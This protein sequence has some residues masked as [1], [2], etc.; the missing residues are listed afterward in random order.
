[1]MSRSISK[2]L[3]AL[4]ILLLITAF[5]NFHCAK[6]IQHDIKYLGQKPPGLEPKKFAPGLVSTDSLVEFG[7]VFSKNGLEFYYGVDYGR[8]SDI[9]AMFYDGNKWTEAVSIFQND[10][11][12]GN[13][14]F[15]S[16]DE[17]ELYFISPMPTN[18]EDSIPD[19][20]IWFCRRS[21]TGWSL[22]VLLPEFINTIR[23]S[24]YYIS[25]SNEGDLYYSSNALANVDASFNFDIYRSELESGT[26][27]HPEPL[28]ESINTLDYEADVF[29]APDETY[30]IF[31]SRRKEGH[32]QGDLY[33]SYKN[34]EGEWTDAVNM[35]GPINT[36]NHELCPFVTKDEQYFFYTSDNDI[37][38][39][40]ATILQN[41]IPKELKVF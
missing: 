36:D 23:G 39:V 6:S 10:N 21:E 31:C 8:K 35:G 15:L 40:S 33:L 12:H 41:Y 26:F 19:F 9:L 27:Q 1:M 38:W 30:L 24:E 18:A 37:Y 11:H 4:F 7:S 2:L 17:Q 20:N 3:P 34:E 13:D 5:S 25:F 28:P 29:V 22:P 32:G 16:N 14:P